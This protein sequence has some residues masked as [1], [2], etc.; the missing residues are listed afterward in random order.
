MLKNEREFLRFQPMH[1]VITHA[2]RLNFA[3]QI[4]NL[5]ATKTKCRHFYTRNGRDN[6][7]YVME[8]GLGGMHFIVTAK[9]TY[10]FRCCSEIAPVE[11]NKSFVKRIPVK[12]FI[13]LLFLIINVLRA[14]MNYFELFLR[15]CLKNRRLTLRFALKDIPP[16]TEQK[17]ETWVNWPIY[18]WKC[19]G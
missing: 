16:I 18:I 11:I 8:V 13:N 2:D 4:L 14:S 9:S 15:Y 10:I 19:G 3:L 6:S 12:Y 1:Y 7:F 17:G 5:S